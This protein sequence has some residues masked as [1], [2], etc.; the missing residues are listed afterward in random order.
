MWAI[1]CA[2]VYVLIFLVHF[3][4]EGTI[5]WD[6]LKFE[7][8]FGGLYNGHMEC[9]QSTLITAHVDYDVIDPSIVDGGEG[10]KFQAMV[11]FKKEK[12]KKYIILKF[13]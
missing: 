13:K 12:K 7:V 10:F 9:W 2:L 1:G 8:T 3:F 11:Y 5:N 4:V 6:S